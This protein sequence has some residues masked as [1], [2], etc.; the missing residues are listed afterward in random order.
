[1]S[2]WRSA[3][4][5]GPTRAIGGA[6]RLFATISGLP[7][8]SSIETRASPTAKAGDRG[9]G[10]EGR[11]LAECIGGGLDGL[12]VTRR[13]RPQGVLNA[14]AELPQNCFGHIAGFWVTK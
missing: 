14:I 5:I 6:M 2:C 7:L 10:V 8:A 12:L 1:M 3:S 13:E 4:V 11:V 9:D